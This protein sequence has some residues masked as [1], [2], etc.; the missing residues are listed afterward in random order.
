MKVADKVRRKRMQP[1]RKRR[2]CLIGKQLLSSFPIPRCLKARCLIIREHDHKIAGRGLTSRATSNI[3]A[4]YPTSPIFS[5][6]GRGQANAVSPAIC[7]RRPFDRDTTIIKVRAEF[8]DS[9]KDLQ[10]ERRA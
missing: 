6:S 9:R 8:H 1:M 5:N 4:S 3:G 2:T 10:T 7:T